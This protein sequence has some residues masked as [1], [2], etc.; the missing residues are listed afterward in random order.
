M[1]QTLDIFTLPLNG[2]QVIEA[3]AGTGKTW[4]LSALYVRLV[5]GHGL[6]SPSSQ[7]LNPPDILVMTFTDLATAELRAR[8]RERLY[9][10]AVYFQ[11]PQI[12]D[13][14]ADE[15]LK[16]LKQ[17][18]DPSEWPHCAKRLD[19]SAQWMDEAAIFTIHSWSARMLK[20]HAFDS[21]SLF[22]Q[23][24]T[25]DA[26]KLKL[27]AAQEYWRRF[28]YPL[29]EQQIIGLKGYPA[30]PQELLDKINNRFLRKN[31]SPSNQISRGISPKL[32]LKDWGAFQTKY[33]QFV[34]PARAAWTNENIK[35]IESTLLT[36]TAAKTLKNY[37][38]DWLG[39][40]LD[41]MQD[42]RAG[43]DIELKT[44]ERFSVAKLHSSGWLEADQVPGLLE[45]DRLCEIL[46]EMPKVEMDDLLD[47][48]A[49]EINAIYE[50]AKSSVGQFDFSDL[51]Q[52]LYRAVHAKESKLAQTIRAQFPVALV[53]E[54]Q[55]T[56]PWQ[57]GTLRK[58]YV[59]QPRI[60]SGLIIIG[61]PKQAIYG[62]RGADLDTYLKARG[63]AGE[64]IFTLPQNFRSTQKLVSAVNHI[65]SSAHQPFKSIDFV[66]VKAAKDIPSL[67]VNNTEQAA[68][69]VWY[70]KSEKPLN[71]DQYNKTMSAVFA[72]QM[73]F[74]LNCGAAHP[75]EMAVL[76]RDFKEAESIRKALALLGV[77]SVYLSD[78]DSV[79]STNEALELRTLLL[80]VANP[81]S[82]SYL[83]S[84][85]STRIWG[86]ELN[87]LEEIIQTEELWE[88]LI[89]RFHRY[90]LIWQRQGFLPMLHCL[91][92]EN[93]IAQNLT[94]SANSDVFNGER[95]LTNLLHLGD[96]LQNASLK[97]QGE[98]SLIRYLEQQ[99]IDPKSSG[100]ASIL[101]L[102]SEANLVKVITIHKSKGLE[103]PLV[104][105]PFISNFKAEGS[106]NERSDQ[107]RLE[108]D[109][110]LL[111]V[112][113]TRAQK[114]LWIGLAPMFRDFTKKS[115]DPKNAVSMILDREK[116]DDLVSKLGLWS[117]CS[118]IQV[119]PLPTPN[120]QRYESTQSTVTPRGALTPTHSFNSSWWTASFSSIAKSTVN[121][122]GGGEHLESSRDDKRA[123][124]QQ[125]NSHN[126]V[127]E[128]PFKK[129]K[130]AES[131]VENTTNLYDLIE[132][133]SSVGTML[134]DL[135]EW[136]FKHDWLITKSCVNGHANQDWNLL[137]DIKSER[138]GLG[139]EGKTILGEWI[140]KIASTC[141]TAMDGGTHI[142]LKSLLLS[143]MNS[144]NA[145]AEMGF[146][147]PVK[148]LD[149]SRLDEL[150]T[151]HV[152]PNKARSGL[153]ARHMNG[154]LTGFMDLVF[155]N[156]GRY[157]V[158]DYKS[159]KLLGYAY[160]HMQESILSHRYDVQYTLYL[161][162]LHRLLKSRL[163]DYDYDHHIGGAIYLFL[164][165]VD[166]PSQ[167]LFVDRP[168]K[169]VILELDNAY[170]G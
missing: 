60:D 124:S 57:Y 158:L 81:K 17:S 162:A 69:T 65:F 39:G 133:N 26:Y 117:T 115:K 21:K 71:K 97:L 46:R 78:K 87:R 85:I 18:F 159:N 45:I 128:L 67:T 166:T 167:G 114:A 137:I 170:K 83:R 14:L 43:A 5:L 51:L 64:H 4:T 129:A 126:L 56:D 55:D 30:S 84:A 153:L 72:D 38:S 7:G 63:D 120:N 93:K 131:E 148:S 146:T 149:V 112:A 36:R 91:I 161:L 102:E 16:K 3:S 89:E 127:D 8:I 15:F 80:A 20:E 25:E 90:H 74:L 86:L 96:L 165:G 70:D 29:S 19:L 94:R 135:L 116:S 24:L 98:G 160:E 11:S 52:N 155:E 139:G 95:V 134:H 144:V 40:W 2:L 12:E 27:S 37:R 75:N 105:L 79:Y 22:E 147:L 33:E 49:Y 138:L 107:S 66:Q 108:E 50:E 136:Q 23:S 110:R 88:G 10:A 31:T 41:K 35:L 13:L 103:F 169:D 113:L 44:L 6:P 157:Y 152:L 106:K 141:F 47:H 118:D 61:D 130:L 100:D 68:I 9:S 123:D 59:E 156:N 32:V 28:L 122:Q 73:V 111:Y 58:I 48:A 151:S 132:S 121:Y 62:F 42:W 125:D 164:R 99:L 82:T 163:A 92:H 77:R 143:D 54:F 150:I 119:S 76:V 168:C 1:S 154:M 142:P 140:Q 101:R 145:W 34:K 109:V 104:F 53:D